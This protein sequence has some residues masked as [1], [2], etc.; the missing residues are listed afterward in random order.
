[1][2]RRAP[3]HAL[4]IDGR[5]DE[6]AWQ[7]AVFTTD[8]LQKDPHEGAA[9]SESTRVAVLYDDDYLYVGARMSCPDPRHHVRASVSRRDNPGNSERFILTLDTYHDRR[10]AYSFGVTATG[11]RT[12]YYHPT[13]GEFSRDHSWD[14]VWSAR[15][16]RLPDGWSCEMKIPFSQLRFRNQDVQTWGIDFNRWVPAESED[17]FLVYIPKNST[18]WASRFPDLTG[19]AGIR[20]KRRLEFLPYV[21]SDAVYDD[22]TAPG[23]PFNDGSHYAGRAG[24]DLKMGL[25][26]NL[27]LDATFNPDF[28]QVE[29]DPAQVNLSAFETFYDEKRPFFT[30]GSQLLQGGGAAYYY[31]RRIGAAPHG[32]TPELFQRP[33]AGG[34]PDTLAVDFAARPQNT[35]ILGAAK[36]TG[37]LN[38]GLSLGALAAVTG[39]E[40]ADLFNATSGARGHGEVEPP[41]AYSVLRLQQELGA[42]ASTIGLSLT[43]VRRDLPEAGPLVGLL[44]K[45]ATTGGIDWD[46]R[47]DEGKYDLSGHT[48]FSHIRGSAEEIAAQQLSSRRYYQRPDID[49]VRFDP[50]RTS[51][52]GYNASLDLN[53]NGG[54]H[55][56]WE[57]GF[58]AES[59]GLELNDLG[60]LSGADDIDTWANLRYRENRVGRWLRN[61]AIGTYVN[62]G[63]NFGWERQYT[64]GD[65]T[66]D[67]QLKNF[68]NVSLDLHPWLSS[69]NDNLTRG[70]PSMRTGGGL[71]ESISINTNGAS[72][73]QAGLNGSYSAN[74]R[75]GWGWSVGTSLQ[76]RT[77]G[78][79]QFSISPGYTQTRPV[80]QYI[81]TLARGDR[82]TA[83][84]GNRY[85]FSRIRQSQLS[86]QLRL[87]Y[88]FTPDLSL[89]IYAEPFAASGR[90]SHFGELA[91]PGSADLR[92]YGRDGT[93]VTRQVDAAGHATYAV[94]DGADQFSIA[95]DDYN[96]VNFNSNVVLRWEWRPGSTFFFVWQQNRSGFDPG[97]EL[98]GARRFF[99]SFSAQ[100]TDYLAAKV[101]Y[102]IPVN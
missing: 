2:A 7:D 73:V 61:Y 12:D 25:G 72:N 6:A 77:G 26:P 88:S 5:L 95:R 58:N 15:T 70:G 24:G 64:E 52:T 63:Y 96:V 76:V 100:G 57:A 13:D 93:T 83:T 97:G 55:W 98:V 37:R 49:Y 74:T 19:L 33:G 46:W 47:I 82:G 44:N 59:P 80:R 3:P 89:E 68:T 65:L 71:S 43:G 4:D 69:E 45:S 40:R 60:R 23:D 36:L 86:T 39:R 27:T 79:W 91:A 17:D 67:T 81:A 94:T 92:L 29:A 18:G 34:H 48:G 75:A 50:T 20:P 84:Y 41:T 51:L 22:H 31:S 62:Q 78:R 16:A 87:N 38:G 99:D 85:V 42:S 21:A 66:F 90:F 28:G 35:T 102:W 14:P 8:F 1:M 101:T 11:V 53:K 54:A 56:L 30:E 32:P 10:T 9:A